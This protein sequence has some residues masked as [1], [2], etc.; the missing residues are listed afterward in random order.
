MLHMGCG[1]GGKGGGTIPSLL[2]MLPHSPL[3]CPYAQCM[4]PRSTPSH[5]Q[6]FTDAPPELPPLPVRLPYHQHRCTASTGSVSVS[7]QPAGALMSLDECFQEAITSADGAEGSPLSK[8]AQQFTQALRQRIE[9]L[10]NR[11]R[12]C[13]HELLET[14]QVTCTGSLVPGTEYLSL[15]SMGYGIHSSLA[16]KLAQEKRSRLVARG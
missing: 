4:R 7:K 16:S 8:S 10:T 2:N 5:S 11:R 3:P 15:P 12:R 6:L 14:V 9:F 13:S 1:G